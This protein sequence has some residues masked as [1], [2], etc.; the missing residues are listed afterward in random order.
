MKVKLAA[1][2]LSD[3]VATSLEFC[4]KENMNGF[5]DCSATINFV[6]LINDLFD[7]FNSRNLHAYGFKRPLQVSNYEECCTFLMT[8][9]SY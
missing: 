1:Q 5:D 4:L 6:R 9:R 3:S 2:L 7:I 8:A